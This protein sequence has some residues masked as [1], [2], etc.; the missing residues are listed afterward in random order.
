[1]SVSPTI[2][3]PTPEYPDYTPR[4]RPIPSSAD[5]LSTG[6]KQK[7]LFNKIYIKEFVATNSAPLP[8][9]YL[10]RSFSTPSDF[11]M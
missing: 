6:P 2:T 1:M 5:A 9:I 10:H 8:V 4:N 7:L 11:S 3:I